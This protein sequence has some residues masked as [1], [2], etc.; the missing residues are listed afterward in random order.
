MGL[1]REQA[2]RENILSRLS[3]SLF[4]HLVSAPATHA[5]ASL[6]EAL[7]KAASKDDI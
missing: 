1:E 4:P 2:I 5:P 3:S 6:K 7:A